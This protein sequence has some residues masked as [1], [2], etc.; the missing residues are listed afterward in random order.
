MYLIRAAVPAD[1][2]EVVAVLARLQVEPAHHI[3]YDGETAEEIAAELARLRP[4][5]ASGSV[6]ATDS[7]GRV[8]GV[9]S[10]ETDP[11]VGRAWLHGYQAAS[12]R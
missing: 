4:D 1:L 10:V 8:R 12:A 11:E 9:L 3:A 7:T 2:D 5:W 6:V